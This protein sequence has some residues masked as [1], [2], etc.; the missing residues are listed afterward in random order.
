MALPFAPPAAGG[1]GESPAPAITAAAAS[2]TAARAAVV[3]AA[4][5][6]APRRPRTRSRSAEEEEQEDK[7]PFSEDAAP[8]PPS[9]VATPI[10]RPRLLPAPTSAAASPSPS[11]APPR[12]TNNSSGGLGPKLGPGRPLR[13]IILGHNPSD[14]A[15][16]TGH[17]YGHGSNKMW[18]LLSRV[19]VSP[20][21]T[22]AGPADDQLPTTAG[23]GFL[24]VGTGHPG[25]QSSSFSSRDFAKWR[26]VFYARLKAH[27]REVSARGVEGCSCGACGAPLAVAF[28]G[29]RQFQ[30]LLALPAM[31]EEE[32]TQVEGGETVAAAAAAAAPAPNK[33]TTS[34]KKKKK[35]GGG[36]GGGG[37]AY[38]R[39]PP[40]E[41]GLQ[42]KLPVGWPLPPSTQ[43]YVTATTSGA[44]GLTNEAREASWRAMWAVVGREPW[45]R[46]VRA[47]CG[48]GGGGGASGGAGGAGGGDVKD[49]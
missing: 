29:K 24:D 32:E 2:A 22:P 28:A 12:T 14:T 26:P 49:E 9:A 43:V 47:V 35:K 5:A 13:L 42:H 1:G 4:A 38:N 16:A 15:W 41:L 18:P 11:P 21:G 7:P 20:A 30:E 46:R 39:L 10:K 44:A 31:T 8:H 19:G 3:F 40:V 45:P 23:V 25:T 33:K 37:G 27:V 17:F 48:G 6:V 34:S 36:G